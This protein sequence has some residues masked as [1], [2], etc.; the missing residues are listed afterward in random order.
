[1]NIFKSAWRKF[2]GA[3]LR[4]QNQRD[5]EELTKLM[6]EA[7]TRIAEAQLQ[8][9]EDARQASVEEAR[10]A[11][12]IVQRDLLPWADINYV[13]GRMKVNAYNKRFVD[14]LRQKMGDLTEG[15]SDDDV[16]KLFTDR[17]NIELE[18]PKLDVVHSGID[19]DGRIKMQLDWNP[20]FIRHLADNGIQAETEEEA[21]QM[22]LSL[23]THQAAED[24]IP[25]M[26]SKEDV[27]AAF[28][29]LTEEA[30]AE[31]AEAARQIEER[32]TAI[33]KSRKTPRKRTTKGSP[34]E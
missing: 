1:M 5:R 17:E 31:L 6:Q 32:S 20:A 9:E 24:I 10:L 4:E 3:K 15:L 21:I 28:H 19:E 34:R 30:T 12:E 13:A 23:L 18:E 8:R 25:E 22:Y 2:T 33:K 14:D 16:I 11:A 7:T 29:D 27:E 26:L